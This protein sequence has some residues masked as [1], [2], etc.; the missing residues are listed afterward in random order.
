[1]RL[2]V[3][4]ICVGVCAHVC[5]GSWCV[6]ECEG[7]WCVCVYE[8]KGAWCGS[9]CVCQVCVRVRERALMMSETQ[10][11]VLM[12]QQ[13]TPSP[14][15]SLWLFV[16][17]SDHSSNS[18]CSTL[19]LIPAVNKSNEQASHRVGGRKCDNADPSLCRALHA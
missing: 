7:S 15:Q 17:Q 11:F 16:L 14:K 12:N 18:C 6:C 4:C 2:S 13:C 10:N 19:T 5:E 9:A 3:G 1:M 8:C